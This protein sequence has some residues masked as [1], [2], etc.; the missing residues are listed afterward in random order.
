VNSS[1]IYQTE[2]KEN[3]WTKP[4]PAPFD[5]DYED[6]DFHFTP[7]SK[8]L[9]FTSKRPSGEGREASKYGHIWVTQMTQS[10]WEQ[11][12][13]LEY[14]VNTPDSHSIYPSLT[15]EGTLYFFSNRE[16]GFG[17][18]DIYRSELVN[19]KY[20]KVENLGEII[21][22]ENWEYDLYIAQDETYLIFSSDRPGGFGRNNDMYIVFRKTDGTWTSPI[23]L[24]KDFCDAGCP[25][26]TLDG[27][28]FF[29][30]SDRTG[31][32]NIYWVDAKIIEELKPE[33]L[34]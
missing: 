7:D 31:I 14:P 1:T 19:G 10:G 11:P 27:K 29:F 30:A 8:T 34:K 5:S 12:R 32:C 33:K 22:T 23:N 13:L 16:G 20:K 3:R 9:Y 17:Q 18:H 28:Y 15:Q 6:W 26:V 4:S 21:N 24:G 2:L 25:S